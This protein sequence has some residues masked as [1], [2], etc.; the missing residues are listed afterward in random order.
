MTMIEGGTLLVATHNAGK[1]EEIARLL[2]PLG[3]A[4]RSAAELGLPVPE[5]TEDT[6]EGN[7]RLKARA[8]VAATGLP[9]LADDSGLEIDGLNGAPGV[10]TAD[11]AETAGGRDYGMAMA[12]AWSEL[13]ARNMPEPRRAR[14]R[15]TLV[16]LWPDGRDAVFEG[17]AEGRIIWP[18]RGVEGHGFD[19]I[20]QPDDHR[21][22]F[23]EMTA[24]EKDAI[25]HRARAVRQLVAWL[26]GR[27]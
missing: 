26:D 4:C 22:S 13:E 20:F 18:P 10:W 19:P 5:E 7:A 21:C 27:S 12:R 9:T 11:W 16:L 24:S 25:S 23:A 14:F 3:I 1:L 2:E 8:A 6:F 15:A 17:I